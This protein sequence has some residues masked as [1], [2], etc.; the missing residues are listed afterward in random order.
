MR[1]FTKKLPIE[2]WHEKNPNKDPANLTLRQ[3][4]E[5]V[6]STYKGTR[7]FFHKKGTNSDEIIAALDALLADATTRGGLSHPLV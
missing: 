1:F 2:E 4:I 6:I 5:F 3:R 7:G